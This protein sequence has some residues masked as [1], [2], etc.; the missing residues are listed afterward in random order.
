MNRALNLFER[1]H[2]RLA[3]IQSRHDIKAIRGPNYFTDVAVL[4]EGKSSRYHRGGPAVFRSALIKP[5]HV[6]TPI[7]AALVLGIVRG[8]RSQPVGAGGQR[9]GGPAPVN[10]APLRFGQFF[11][12]HLAIGLDADQGQAHLRR[13][14]VMGS[15]LFIYRPNFPRR[16]RDLFEAGFEFQ[17][18][19]L[20]GEH[21]FV[22]AP[23]VRIVLQARGFGFLQAQLA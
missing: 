17:I 11:F 4:R 20:A 15:F 12:A 6:S 10:N 13:P 1:R 7:A 23:H 8:G 19:D 9:Q 22:A 5:S 14:G 16:Y 2:H 3:R 21:G 18:L